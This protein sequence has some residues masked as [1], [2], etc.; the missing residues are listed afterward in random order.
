MRMTYKGDWMYNEHIVTDQNPLEIAKM[1]IWEKILDRTP[2]NI[3][4]IVKIVSFNASKLLM[5]C[6]DCTRTQIV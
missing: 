5:K 3:P 1:C 2:N 6:M 4:Y